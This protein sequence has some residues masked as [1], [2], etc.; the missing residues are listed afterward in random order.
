MDSVLNV[1]RT[2]HI[3]MGKYKVGTNIPIPTHEDLNMIVI[4]EGK[5]KCR[6]YVKLVCRIG[7]CGHLIRKLNGGLTG[8]K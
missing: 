1:D 5:T 4:M 2:Y 3:Y 7:K 6:L 8:E